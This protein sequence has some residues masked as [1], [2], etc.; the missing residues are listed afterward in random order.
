MYK[1]KLLSGSI[2]TIK[3]LV[4]SK[5]N[6]ENFIYEVTTIGRIHHMNVVTHWILCN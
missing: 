6:G 4:N 5:A 1:G 3:V 2:V